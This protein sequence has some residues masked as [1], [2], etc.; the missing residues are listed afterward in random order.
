MLRLLNNRTSHSEPDS[1][2]TTS[3]TEH[4]VTHRDTI[5]PQGLRWR[6]DT[7]DSSLTQQKALP[8]TVTATPAMVF[9][10]ELDDKDS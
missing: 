10:N 4:P 9:I 7:P 8:D 5:K 1:K 3:N 6:P 2:P